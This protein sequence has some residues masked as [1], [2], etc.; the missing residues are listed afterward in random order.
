MTTY[1]LKCMLFFNTK[2]NFSSSTMW[3]KIGQ[4][5]FLIKM[6]NLHVNQSNL[7]YLT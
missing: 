7:A 4:I 3:V 1:P 5:I 6:L 2:P